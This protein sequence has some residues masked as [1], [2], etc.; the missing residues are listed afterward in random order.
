MWRIRPSTGSSNTLVRLSS[1]FQ[2]KQLPTDNQPVKKSQAESSHHIISLGNNQ[3]AYLPILVPFQNSIPQGQ[4]SDISMPA[5][6]KKKKKQKK[7]RCRKNFKK[8]IKQKIIDVYYDIINAH[9]YLSIRSASKL[10]YEQ[11]SKD[12]Y[13]LIL[14]SL[15]Y[16]SFVH[17]SQNIL[18]FL[19]NYRQK[20]RREGL[21]NDIP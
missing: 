3:Y 7:S 20:E 15:W 21:C 19:Y 5:S 12:E 1:S 13:I 4:V 9:P 10:I 16:R 18:T 14:T 8:G 17:S 11:L 6:A 2:N